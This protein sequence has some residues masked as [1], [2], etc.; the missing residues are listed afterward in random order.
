MIVTPYLLTIIY[1]NHIIFVQPPSCP[2]RAASSGSAT[3]GAKPPS[4]PTAVESRPEK[5]TRLEIWGQK[6]SGSKRWKNMENE[7][8]TMVSME[9]RIS[10][11]FNRWK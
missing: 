5:K 8:F 1:N 6:G 9:M 10:P 7:N 2:F 4:S 3:A 11:K